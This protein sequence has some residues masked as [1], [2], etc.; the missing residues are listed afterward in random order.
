MDLLTF[1]A[2]VLPEPHTVT[3]EPYEGGAGYGDSYGTGVEVT[4][5][6]DQKRRLVRAPDGSQVVSESTVYAPLDTVAPTRSRVTLP[7]GQTTIVI[8]AARRTAAGV[9][10][11]PEHLEIACE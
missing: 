6:V 5:F 8:S 10:E 11:A 9:A 4:C 7:D 3:V 2:E 1:L